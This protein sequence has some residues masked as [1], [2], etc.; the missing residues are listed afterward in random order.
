MNKILKFFLPR[1][2]NNNPQNLNYNSKIYKEWPLKSK[3]IILINNNRIVLKVLE[4]NK[5]IINKCLML[6]QHRLEIIFQKQQA[7]NII[8]PLLGCISNRLNNKISSSNNKIGIEIY[9]RKNNNLR[10]W[11]EDFLLL[12]PVVLN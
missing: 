3:I 8:K 2:N 4:R 6:F 11:I 10:N 7:K 9:L 5:L 1:C 12:N